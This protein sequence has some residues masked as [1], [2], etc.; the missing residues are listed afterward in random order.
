MGA[1]L[2][3]QPRVQASIF[4]FEQVSSEVSRTTDSYSFSALCQAAECLILEGN[5]LR[6]TCITFMDRLNVPYLDRIWHSAPH[7]A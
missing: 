3:A 1:W 5:L 6:V 7:L 2:L 4:V